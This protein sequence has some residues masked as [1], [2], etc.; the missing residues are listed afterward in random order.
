MPEAKTSFF[1]FLEFRLEEL[2]FKRNEDMDPNIEYQYSV[3]FE[4]KATD[5]EPQIDIT[6]T[7]PGADNPE[8]V[9][10]V[11]L[12]LRIDWTPEEGPFQFRLK[13]TGVFREKDPMDDK[14]YRQY[15]EIH[16]PSVLFTH[17]RPIVRSVMSDAGESFRLPLM[18]LSESIREQRQ[19]EATVNEL[20][21]D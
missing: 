17:A 5:I 8:R 18:N 20:E 4:T 1:Q 11:T 10:L 7:P 13:M 16:A 2:I 21:S 14:T 9:T 3:G 19:R 12:A 15:I 6:E